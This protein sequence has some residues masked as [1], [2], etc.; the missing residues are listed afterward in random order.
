M[1]K[2]EARLEKVADEKWSEGAATEDEEA[3]AGLSLYTPS[4]VTP[5]PLTPFP[6]WR[7]LLVAPPGAASTFCVLPFSF[8]DTGPCLV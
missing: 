1:R 8:P 2:L 6:C 7:E 4:L 3:A 5:L